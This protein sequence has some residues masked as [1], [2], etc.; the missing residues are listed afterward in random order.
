M[1]I[2]EISFE[3]ALAK[4]ENSVNKLSSGEVKLDEAFSLFEEGIKYAK[5]CEEKLTNVEEKVAK[6]IKNGKE[7]DFKVEE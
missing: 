2:K 5:I 3:E 1:D 4:L 7:E 6:I